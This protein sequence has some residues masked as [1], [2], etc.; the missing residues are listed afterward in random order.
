[1]KAGQSLLLLV[2][3]GASALAEVPQQ[4]FGLEALRAENAKLLASGLD[5]HA[6]N[7]R[8]REFSRIKGGGLLSHFSGARADVLAISDV[9]GDDIAVIGSGIGACPPTP[10]FKCRTRIVASNAIARQSAAAQAGVLGMPVFA[11]EENLYGDVYIVAKRLGVA[12]RNQA[13]GVAIHGGEPTVMLPE[14]PGEGG[15]NQALA[16]ALAREIDGL[17]NVCVLVAGTDGTDGPTEAAGGIV[18]G[19][20][21]A[22]LPGGDD[23]LERADAGTWLKQAGCLFVTGPTGTNV[24][25]LMVVVRAD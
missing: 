7:A 21:W 17:E 24:M 13:P 8:R 9:S 11:N 1:M 2:S 18:T 3:G 22:L 16:L 23:A 5:I 12:I 15:R 10:G 14:S 4:G 19:Q 6:V 20:S 25:D